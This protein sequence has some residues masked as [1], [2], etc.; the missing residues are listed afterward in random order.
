MTRSRLC[1]H[2]HMELT[3]TPPPSPTR[4]LGVHNIHISVDIN[5]TPYCEMADASAGS[6]A[7]RVKI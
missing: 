2:E 7:I 6:T 5:V 1:Q 4:Q 3:H